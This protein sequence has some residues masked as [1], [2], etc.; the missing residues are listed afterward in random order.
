MQLTLKRCFLCRWPTFGADLFHVTTDATLETS[1]AVELIVYRLAPLM[2]IYQL[3]A[4]LVI[5]DVY[6]ILS[7]LKELISN[8]A[9]AVVVTP[10]AICLTIALEFDSPTLGH[11]AFVCRLSIIR[12]T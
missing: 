10:V 3:P 6:L 2:Q 9:F 7:S 12:N 4:F 11:G 1:E 8:N 5:W